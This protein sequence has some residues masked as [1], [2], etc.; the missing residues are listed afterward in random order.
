MLQGIYKF[1]ISRRLE[2]SRS[3]KW[4]GRVERMGRRKMRK[5]LCG[6]NMKEV[7]HLEYP[8]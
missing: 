6:K 7:D 5:S 1:S 4:A 8:A 3:M 2:K